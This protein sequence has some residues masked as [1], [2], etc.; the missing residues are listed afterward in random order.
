LRPFGIEL[1]HHHTRATLG[2]FLGQCP[3]D[4]AIAR[5]IGAT[6][7]MAVNA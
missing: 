2:E 6:A 3:P 5:V 7:T 1:G 4:P